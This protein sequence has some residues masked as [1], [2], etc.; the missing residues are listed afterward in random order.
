[1]R[2]VLAGPGRLETLWARSLPP[3]VEVRNRLIGDDETLDLFRRSGPLVLPY[4]DATQ[5]ALVAHAYFFRKP[6]IVTR[7]GAL[8]EYVV[9]GET[10]WIVPP[11]NPLA[12]A[13][14]MQ[15]ALSDPA[16]LQGMGQAGRAWYECQR[17]AEGDTLQG[18][19]DRLAGH[20][21]DR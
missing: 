10:G 3:G 11:E 15:A 21:R 9:E 12:L 17:Q 2:L 14:A 20:R 5:S 18:M 13:E 4:R 6:V 8:P 1:V 16:Q 19:Y 7:V